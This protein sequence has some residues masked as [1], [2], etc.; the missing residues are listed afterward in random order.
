[1]AIIP[2]SKWQGTGNDFI[3]IDDRE[4]VFPVEDLQL[5][6]KLCDRHFGIGSD[7]LVLLRRPTAEGAAYHMEFLNPDGSQSFCGNG[8]RCAYAFWCEVAKD[9]SD[10]R[11]TAIDGEH[12]ARWVEGEVEVAMRDVHG[13]EQVDADTDLL[14]TGSPHL[15]LWVDDPAAIDII[16]AARLHRYGKRFRAEGVNV[17]F[18]RWHDGRV[19]M[20][21]YERGVEAETLSCG[22]GVTAAALS[23][24]A[25]GRGNGN[26]AVRTAG[27]A[28]LVTARKDGSS[29]TD[30]R[31][32]GPVRK[33][34][35]GSV[36]P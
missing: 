2:F 19:E 20:R 6:R 26:V 33:V 9:R 15:V 30:V 28:L 21:T 25:R 11:F 18:V 23:A 24:M 27:G 35:E 34:F 8:S 10:A 5:V 36:E 22:T 7:G 29:F 3:L 4:A 14:N 1:M 32:R 17:N 12:G 16:P 13:S 31:L